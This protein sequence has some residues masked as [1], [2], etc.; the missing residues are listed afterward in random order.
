MPTVNPHTTPITSATP[1]TLTMSDD[2]LV[3]FGTPTADG[4]PFHDQGFMPV[5]A[6]TI[7]GTPLNQ[8]PGNNGNLFIRYTGDGT[9]SL[10][11]NGLPTAVYSTLQYELVRYNGAGKFGHAA[12]GSLTMK[13]VGNPTVIGSGHLLNGQLDF[14]PDGSITGHLAATFQTSG[15]PAGTIDIAVNH[16][17]GDVHFLAGGLTLDGGTLLATYTPSLSS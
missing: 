14:A 10:D 7:A 2:A 9:Q 13:G 17:P 11:A 6:A 12:D 16:A 8:P 15:Q 5:T 3:T 4:V 1:F